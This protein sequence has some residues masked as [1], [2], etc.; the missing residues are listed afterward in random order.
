MK[1]RWLLLILLILLAAGC[2]TRIPVYSPRQTDTEAHRTAQAPKD[3]LECHD[4]SK[5]PSHKPSDDC[6]ECH[7]I[8]KGS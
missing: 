3:C 7:K 5:R 8:S 4:I 2:V 1:K 6:R